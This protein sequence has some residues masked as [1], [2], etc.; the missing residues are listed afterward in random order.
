MENI[1]KILLQQQKTTTKNLCT[2]EHGW[3]SA[4]FFPSYEKKRYIA[5]HDH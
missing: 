3:M 4:F 1:S 2:F 5:R